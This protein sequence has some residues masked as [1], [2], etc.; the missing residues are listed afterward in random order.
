MLDRQILLS[1]LTNQD[2]CKGESRLTMQLH[3]V[4]RSQFASGSIVEGEVV[5]LL[6]R[7]DTR[8]SWVAVSKTVST[9]CRLEKM[10]C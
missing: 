6:S 10:Q 5:A 8:I 7:G 3:Q 1:L 2:L 9:R 4:N